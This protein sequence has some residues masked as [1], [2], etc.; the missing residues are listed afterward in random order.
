MGNRAAVQLH[1]GEAERGLGD[2][3]GQRRE[4]AEGEAQQELSNHCSRRGC[5][6]PFAEGLGAELLT[7]NV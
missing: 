4:L 3:V 7:Q 2:L 6:E 1:R 5:T